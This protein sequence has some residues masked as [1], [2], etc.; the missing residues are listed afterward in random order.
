[1]RRIHSFIVLLLLAAAVPADAQRAGEAP[2]RP[3]LTAGADSNDARAY[4]QLAE[5]SLADR[6]REAADAFYWA[7]QLNP[8]LADALYGRYTALLMADPRLLVPY[9]DGERRLARNPQ[10]IMLDSLYFRAL[11]L[12]PLLYR[13]YESSLFRLYTDTWIREAFDRGGLHS[14]TDADKA[15]FVQQWLQES[16]PYVRAREAYAAGRFADALRLYSDAISQARRKSYLRTERARLHAHMGSIPAAL[17]DMAE[18]LQEKRRED[19]NQRELVHLY[20]SKALLEHG[21]GMLHE[22]NNDRAAAREA[23]GRALTEDLS[24]YP[25]HVRMGALALAEGNA[26]TAEAEYALAAQTSN[27]PSVIYTYGAVLA[28]TGKFDEAAAQFERASQAAPHYPDP[29]FGLAM[30]RDAQGNATAAAEGYR[31]FLQRAS[32]AHGRRA[33]AEQR[34]QALAAGA[35]P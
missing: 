4:M 32:R 6:P 30:V 22:R 21:I 33:H 19:D 25:A 31:N 20:E 12:D 13:K 8:T 27:E 11:T 34:V 7:S 3:R 35:T 2:R 15:R 29:Y 14:A 1:M 26:E 9:W 18:A 17:T 10:V 5:R 24:F 16:G 28:Q 23:Y